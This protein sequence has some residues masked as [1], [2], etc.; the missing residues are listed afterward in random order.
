MSR[1]ALLT[2]PRGRSSLIRP[3]VSFSAH[4]FTSLVTSTALFWK[5]TEDKAALK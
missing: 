5:S 4:E 1:V 2:D 3:F